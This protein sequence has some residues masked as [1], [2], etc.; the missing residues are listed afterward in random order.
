MAI[1]SIFFVSVV[2]AGNVGATELQNVITDVKLLDGNDT[3]VTV[4]SNNVY[5]LRTGQTYRLRFEFDLS[6]YDGKLQNDDTFS[7]QLPA[8]LDVSSATSQLYDRTTGTNVGEVVTTS[9]GSG[10]GATVTV[11]VKNLETYLAATGGNV[12]KNVLGDFAANF[13]I[14]QDLTNH[15]VSFDSSVMKNAVTQVYTTTSRTATVTGYENFAQNGGQAQYGSWFSQTLKNNN[16]TNAGFFY[17]QWRARINTGA[18]NL[19][20]NVLVHDEVSAGNIHYIPES[21]EIYSTAMLT[22]RTSGV[23][24]LTDAVKLTEGTDYSIKWNANFTSFD[25]TLVDGS[26]QYWIVYKTTT[27]NDGSLVANTLSVSKA[28]G[29]A[30]TQRNDNTRTYAKQESTSLYSG[31][32]VGNS[33][34]KKVLTKVKVLNGNDTEQNV[35]AN[36]IYQL[37]THETYKLRFEFDLSNYDGKLNNGDKFSFNIPQPLDIT[38]ETVQLHDSDTDVVIGEAAIVKN[39]EGLGA[40]VTVTLKNLEEYLSATGGQSVVGVAGDFAAYFKIDKDITDYSVSYNSDVMKEAVTHRY[41]TTSYNGK[42]AT[43]YENFAQNG[44]QAQR[45]KWSSDALGTSGKFY[46]LWRVRVNTGKQDFGTNF[47]VHDEVTKG[48]IQYIPESL[49]VYSTA[50]L[51]DR[52]SGTG[53]LK[54]AVLLKAGKDYTVKW[55]ATYTAFDIVFPDGKKQYWITY[56]TTTPNDGSLIANSLSVTKAD[57]T[58]LTQRSN[59]KRTVSTQESTSLYSGKLDGQYN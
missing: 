34:L 5:Q 13:K 1:C 14:D 52:T 38:N 45:G 39:G 16:L 4:D 46:S 54:D 9:N 57:G 50:K 15:T 53:L 48:A 6:A 56:K 18:Q 41:T 33:D 43:D 49:E 30:L 22:Q 42:A 20:A 31:T 12:V 44:G 17:S 2:S 23:A 11:T 25:L 37:R 7:F 51:T 35:D 58:A 40:T 19:G 10:A 24:V 59:N 26:K 28:D 29:T 47:V 32:M 3:A 36:G 8:P 27:P 55:N 21:F